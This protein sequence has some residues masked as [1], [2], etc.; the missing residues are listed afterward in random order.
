MPYAFDDPAARGF[1][2]SYSLRLRGVEPVRYTVR[3][4]QLQMDRAGPTDCTISTNTQSFLRVG[5]GR[6]ALTGRRR[7]CGRKPW[8]AFKVDTL[9]PAIPH[10]G[11]VAR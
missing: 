7:P 6:A 1:T 8:L 9:F 5:I 10:G 4:G 11:G 3:D 2:G